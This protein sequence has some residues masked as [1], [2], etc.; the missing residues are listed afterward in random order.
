MSA[1]V[2]V[3]GGGY[4]GIA[5]AKALDD[6]ADVALIEPRDAFVH[7]V[8]ALRGLVD[9]VW[10]DRLF[11]PYD[12][13]LEHGRVLRSRAVRVDSEAVTLDSGERISADYIVLATGSRYPFPAKLDMDDSAA[14]KAKIRA[15]HEALTHADRVL[16]LGA[17]PVGLELAGE[18]TAAWPNKAVTIVDPVDEILSGEFTKEFRTELRRQL[19]T[20]GVELVLGTSL[21]EE[22]PSLAGETAPFTTTTK[23]GRE[24]TADIW[25]RCFG[26][27]PTTDYLTRALTTPRQANGHIDVTPEL[28][29]PGQEHIFAI[30]D[31]TA[32]PEAKTAKAAGQ[33]AEVAATNIKTLLDGGD[34][35]T[36][37]E[38]DPPGIS[39]PLGP[40]G[41]ASYA[42]HV[43][44]LDAATTSRL[45]GA[46]L[47]I[48]SYLELIGQTEPAKAAGFEQDPD[49]SAGRRHPSAQGVSQ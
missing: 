37:Y 32:I 33:H 39:I 15:T 1:T 10:T 31:M 36:S 41:G 6:V 5:V 30:G 3:V 35:L 12:K 21:R 16:L 40:S 4:G 42:P 26:V 49:A 28:R 22:P 48:R 9:L 46:D 18:I 14:A 19:D 27:L 34:R 7:N 23:S 25:F 2:A 20:L 8:A 38:P 43:G 45:K 24:I 11:M 44:I 13:L 17:G 29:L 47:R